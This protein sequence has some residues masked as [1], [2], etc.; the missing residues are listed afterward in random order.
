MSDERLQRLYRLAM[1]RRAAQGGSCQVSPETMVDVLENRLPEADRQRVLLAVMNDPT[2]RREFE[3]LRAVVEGASPSA[4]HRW[5][6]WQLG[7]A[8]TVAVAVGAGLIWGRLPKPADLEPERAGGVGQVLLVSPEA[9]GNPGA[10]RRFVW[11]GIPGAIRYEYT[12]VTTGGRAV[13][14]SSV[15]DTTLTLPR[16]DSL[17]INPGEELRWWVEATLADGHQVRSALRR[18]QISSP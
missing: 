12:L 7:L 14:V 16:L 3:L 18:L 1:E 10:D 15:T 17:N 8:A 13:F 5:T 4:R 6:G 2:C 11:H 9:G